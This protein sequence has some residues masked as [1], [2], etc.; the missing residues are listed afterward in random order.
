M[1][2]EITEAEALKYRPVGWQIGGW[3]LR[4]S[5]TANRYL[6]AKCTRGRWY[7]QPAPEAVINGWRQ[8]LAAVAEN[9]A[10]TDAGRFGYAAHVANGGD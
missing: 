3:Q 10:A 1:A 8:H 7:Y 9:E 2:H 5:A 4:Y 6:I